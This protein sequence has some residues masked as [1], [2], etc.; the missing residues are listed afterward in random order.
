M[1]KSDILTCNKKALCKVQSVSLQYLYSC[2]DEEASA[3]AA[4]IVNCHIGAWCIFKRESAAGT[5]QCQ[6]LTLSSHKKSFAKG[7]R[8][9]D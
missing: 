7:M 2:G 1:T 9:S 3:S 6:M 8:V 5:I 4:L